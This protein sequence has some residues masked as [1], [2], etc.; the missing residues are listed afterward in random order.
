MTRLTL[1]YPSN[2]ISVELLHPCLVSPT[3]IGQRL[4]PGLV[5]GR[6]R[7]FTFL[8]AMLHAGP[9][10]VGTRAQGY[11]VWV[12]LVGRFRIL[13]TM[14]SMMMHVVEDWND[15]MRSGIRIFSQCTVN[16]KLGIRTD[17]HAAYA[18]GVVG[19][20]ARGDR[21]VA[22]MRDSASTANHCQPWFH[23]L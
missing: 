5:S 19:R 17:G 15:G 20:L 14:G 3:L 11:I 16:Q 23:K 4:G 21:C 1:K 22:M 8:K 6:V 12:P 18:A 10:V 13:L 2:G 7:L 9:F